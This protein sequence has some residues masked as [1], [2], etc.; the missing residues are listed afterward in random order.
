MPTKKPA[1]V[2]EVV[3]TGANVYPEKIPIRKVADALSAVQ[4]LA[5]GEVIG[6]EEDEEE[7]A[8][9][10]VRLL[11]VTRTASAV[12][13]FVGASPGLAI[14]RLR[15]AGKILQDPETAGQSEYILRP[16]KDLSAIA[17][18]LD[19]SVVLREAAGEREV[20][21]RI[22]RD[23]Y[24]RISRSLLLSGNTELSGIVQRVGGATAIRCA[25]RVSF[26]PK[27]LFCRVDAES[28]ARQLG[29][30]LY[31]R[32]IV[33]GTARW[34]KTTMRIFSFV[35]KDVSRLKGGSLSEHLAAL[36]DAGLSD[37]EKLDNPDA[38]LQEIRG[39]V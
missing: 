37:W 6:E 30:A 34:F 17:G 29:D 26:Q 19:C 10:A 25:L 3:F 21:A 27:L 5:T 24:S 22:E 7:E 13:R 8:D 33:H 31:Q 18:K 16:V 32:V 38:Y 11:D 23:S 20:L 1:P 14:Q 28:V 39:D 9:G 12:F 2:F 15:E 4:R 35:I 36:W